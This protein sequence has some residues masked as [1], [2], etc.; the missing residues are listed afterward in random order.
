ML[1]QIL[2][3]GIVVLVLA[4]PLILAAVYLVTERGRR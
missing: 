2:I 3:T 1:E 4:A